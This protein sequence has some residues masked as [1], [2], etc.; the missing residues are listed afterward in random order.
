MTAEDIESQASVMLQVVN[1]FYQGIM[2]IQIPPYV[3]F[4]FPRYTERLRGNYWW[5]L[6]PDY[7][8]PVIQFT[9]LQKLEHC[10]ALRDPGH[11]FLIAYF[12]AEL[13]G[14]SL[15]TSLII[16][17]CPDQSDHNIDFWCTKYSF[18]WFCPHTT[19]TPTS[20]GDNIQG[21]SGGCA[22][23]VES[24]DRI[25]IPPYGLWRGLKPLAEGAFGSYKVLSTLNET[26]SMNLA[27]FAA[28]I[29]VIDDFAPW[30]TQT[31][32]QCSWFALLVFSL[33]K[34]EA[35]GEETPGEDIDE[36]GTRLGMTLLENIHDDE[37][38]AIT[39]LGRPILKTGL[40]P[41]EVGV[42]VFH[43][44]SIPRRKVD[45]ATRLREENA[46]YLMDALGYLYA[47]WSPSF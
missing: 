25:M 45:E 34:D 12:T 32:H 8:L 36:R 18:K 11:E 21:T 31:M 42:P 19:P 17:R 46:R 2:R 24:M 6:M 15:Q 16:D 20:S 33:V 13:Y 41:S 4:I 22:E 47:L 9:F 40:R 39:H 27:Q 35:G 44:S 26:R 23:P 3:T 5:G 38:A 37:E 7:N 1:D 30:Y 43:A 29:E 10:K 14:K 28:L